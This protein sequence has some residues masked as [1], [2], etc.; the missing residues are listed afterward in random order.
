[1]RHYT[2][3]PPKNAYP[4]TIQHFRLKIDIISF[5]TGKH[6]AYHGKYYAYHNTLTI[7]Q[8]PRHGWG[9]TPP[10]RLPLTI[11]HFQLKTDYFPLKQV[12]TTLTNAYRRLPWDSGPDRGVYPPL[13]NAYRLPNSIF[14]VF[15]SKT[16]KYDAYQTLTDAYHEGVDPPSKT[17]TAYHTAFL[18]Y[19]AL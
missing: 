13:Q 1:M 16:G 8:C 3:P 5:K 11:Q 19:L 18:M 9:P 14:N 4:L 17:L 7:C 15:S 6:D 10:K 12:S 2:H